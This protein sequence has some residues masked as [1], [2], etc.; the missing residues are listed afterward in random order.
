[1]LPVMPDHSLKSMAEVVGTLPPGDIPAAWYLSL[2]DEVLAKYEEWRQA[3]AAW[4]D[5]YAEMCEKC[6][7]PAST[8]FRGLGDDTIV[9]LDLP[10]TTDWAWW[11]KTREGYWVPRKRTRAEKTSEAY[12]RFHA[13]RRIP[14]VLNYV[15]GMPHSV[16]IEGLG[17]DWA[18]HVYPVKLRKPGQAVLAFVGA[19]PDKTTFT[20]FEV[21]PQWSRMKLSVYHA[22][23]ERQEA[24]QQ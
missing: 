15:P 17:N 14:H 7:F 12:Q 19:D 10:E 8:G 11:R 23:K 18:T 13:V 1:M 4:K 22:L 2:D 24:S 20:P 3:H 16:W 9:G 6:G 21:G 5:R